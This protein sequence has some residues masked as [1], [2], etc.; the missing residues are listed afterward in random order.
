MSNRTTESAPP[1]VAAEARRLLQEWKEAGVRAREAHEASNVVSFGGASYQEVRAA[2]ERANAVQG[3]QLA[4]E[5]QICELG[6]AALG[7][8]P[9]DLREGEDVAVMVEGWVFVVSHCSKPGEF[10][11]S[12]IPPEDVVRLA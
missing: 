12:F 4:I 2:D 11:S 7:R 3:E 6:L 5:D 8:S 1:D 9:R 10:Y